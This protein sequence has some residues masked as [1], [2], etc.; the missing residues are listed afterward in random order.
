[1][2]MLSAYA[3]SRFLASPSVTATVATSHNRQAIG[4][5]FIRTELF[6]GT[7][8]P[9]GSEVTTK[10]WKKFLNNEITPRF[11][12]G[13]TVLNGSGQFR[14]NS[15][16]IIKEKSMLLILLYPLKT[17]AESNAKIEEIRA[18][19]KRAFQQQSVLRADDLDNVTVSF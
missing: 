4:D 11:P 15:S 1:M 19:Y 5:P 13:L 9:D 18:A 7:R 12:D 2:V 3:S 10:E 16:E 8:K 17:R 14:D 6:F